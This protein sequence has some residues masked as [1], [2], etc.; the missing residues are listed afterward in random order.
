MAYCRFSFLLLPFIISAL[1]ASA[2]A[3]ERDSVR[4]YYHDGITVHAKK[5]SISRKEFPADKGTLGGVLEKNGFSVIRKGVF[6][7]QDLYADGMKK[8][9]IPVVVDDERYQCACP[10]RMDA[11]V[12]RISPL[13][14]ESV[15]LDKSASNLQAGLGGA[16]LVRRSEPQDSLRWRGSVT[17]YMG[18][19]DGTDAAFQVEKSSHRVSVRYVEGEPYENGDGKSFKDLYNYRENAPYRFGETSLLG[20][21]GQWKYS[22]S[23]MYSEDISFPYLLMDERNSLVYNASLAYNDAYKF[24][25][26]YTDHTMDNGL[27]SSYSTMQM[28]TDA[29]NLTL[30]VKSDF[31]EAYYRRW[32]ADNSI[33]NKMT[34]IQNN[35]IPDVNLAAFSVQKKAD[36]NGISVAGKAGLSYYHIGNEAVL[37]YLR[38]LHPG[39]DNDLLF[40]TFG[41]SFSHSLPVSKSLSL[42]TMLDVASEAPEAENLFINVRKMKNTVWTSGNPELDQ[43]LRATLRTSLS[44]DWA[45]LELF[46][47]YIYHYVTIESATVG[48]QRYLTYSNINALLAGASLELKYRWLDVNASY[49]YGNNETDDRPLIEILPLRITTTLTTPEFSGFRLYVRHKYEHSQNRVDS[50]LMETA[51]GS[52]NTVDAGIMARYKGLSCS[53]DVENIGD[54]SYYRHLSYLRDPFASGY[55]VYEPGI[56]ASLNIRYAFN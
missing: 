50:V 19:F 9:D 43:P 20:K 27:R 13:D 49:T 15:E 45:K 56:S 22:A 31:F 12:S 18:S 3:S 24:S 21:S 30:G 28:R 29:T 41:L 39:A 14:I 47:S 32:N 33:R 23:F 17:R 25:V 48:T 37:P 1:S 52:W 38:T 36:F 2:S 34:S 4:V 16:V 26:N 42:G 7:A 35:M 51:T 53:L 10:N 46:G 55:R 11:P 40:P 54:A 8:S 5:H 6:L 44:S